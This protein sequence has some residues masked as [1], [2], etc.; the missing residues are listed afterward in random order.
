MHS[1][2]DQ[3]FR[4][5][6]TLKWGAIKRF[7]NRLLIVANAAETLLPFIPDRVRNQ[8]GRH[9]DPKRATAEDRVRNLLL[10]GSG[11][12]IAEV[13][14]MDDWV[15]LDPKELGVPDEMED[16]SRDIAEHIL[17]RYYDEDAQYLADFKAGSA[18]EPN[19]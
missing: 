3:A 1:E 16:K 6:E 9:L 17:K 2:R 10:G 11:G 8:S 18:A 13:K 4:E 5:S 19:T 15:P 7:A 14:D 12:W